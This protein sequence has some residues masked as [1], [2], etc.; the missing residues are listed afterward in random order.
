MNG[1]ANGALCKIGA[2]Q[3]GILRM[4]LLRNGVF[5]DQV[6]WGILADDWRRRR[7]FTAPAVTH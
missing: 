5:F 4:S 6:L 3:E 1:R 7:R 2:V